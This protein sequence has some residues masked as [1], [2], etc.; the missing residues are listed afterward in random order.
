MTRPPVSC[1]HAIA[2]VGP[3]RQSERPSAEASG[4]RRFVLPSRVF[5]PLPKAGLSQ[6]TAR[7]LGGGRSAARRVVSGG[8]LAHPRKRTKHG[9]RGTVAQRP[10]RA[11]RQGAKVTS[12][13]SGES[14]PLCVVRVSHRASA[15]VASAATSTM[16]MHGARSGPEQPPAQ[17]R[18][19]KP[20]AS[21]SQQ[22]TT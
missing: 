21:S 19:D 5:L 22:E 13:I 18:S 20:G 6:W 4:N 8:M 7:P 1:W 10:E 15:S 16:R 3:A 17:E 14:E 11:P 9:R 2:A 12:R